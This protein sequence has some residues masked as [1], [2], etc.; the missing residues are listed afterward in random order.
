[1]KQIAQPIRKSQQSKGSKK[2]DQQSFGK[3]GWV[4]IIRA[5]VIALGLIGSALI[6]VWL[7]NKS[8]DSRLANLKPIHMQGGTFE[9]SY[10]QSDWTLDKSDDEVVPKPA[11]SGI[12]P[13]ILVNCSKAAPRKYA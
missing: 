11:D 8:I 9:F 12:A 10:E 6:N 7:A 3:K 2:D 4:F 13:M 5:G 1:M